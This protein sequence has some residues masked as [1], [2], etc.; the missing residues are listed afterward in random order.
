MTTTTAAAATDAFTSVSTTTVH[1]GCVIWKDDVEHEKKKTNFFS[2]FQQYRFI[3]VAKMS[4]ILTEHDMSLAT[5]I[6]LDQCYVWST[7]LYGCETWSLPQTN[8]MKLRGL[9]MWMYRRVGR[10]SWK[11][12]KTNK[13]VLNKLGLQSTK[14]MTVVR[15]KIVRFYGHVRRHNSL[16][17]IITEGMV[18]G[19][20]GRGRKR[21]GWLGNVSRY[22]GMIINR[23]AEIATN[24]EEWRT[25]VS[26]VVSDKEQR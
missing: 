13:E 9:E 10:V 8:E 6:R 3:N 19:K 2:H 25:I 1:R 23:C 4:R 20:R 11:A 18:N 17:R 14:L 7:L 22:A 26:N 16:Q 5:K 21:C 12:K 15:Q 24:K